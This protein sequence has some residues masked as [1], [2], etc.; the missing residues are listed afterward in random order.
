MA[1]A[2]RRKGS[3]ELTWADLAE[4]ADGLVG[5]RA[6]ALPAWPREARQR[7][8]PGAS[9]TANS[10]ATAAILLAE[11]HCGP[12]DEYR[13]E[14][15]QQLSR[16]THLPLV[17]AGDVYYHVPARQ[18]LQHVLTAIRHGVTVAEAGHLCFPTPSGT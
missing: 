18:P 14:Q 3:C 4:H 8:G 11:L 15:L 12:D 2:A 16:S 5:G 13:L 6:L 7:Y 10:S 9:A 17:A 1:G